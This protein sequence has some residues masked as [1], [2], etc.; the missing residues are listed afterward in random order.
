MLNA[1]RDP[2]FVLHGGLERFSSDSPYKSHCPACPDGILIVS[3]DPDTFNL[4][5]ADRCVVCAQA[6]VYA[7][8]DS[9]RIRGAEG[10]LPLHGEL[11]L[12]RIVAFVLLR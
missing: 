5:R 9:Y 1:R 12:M 8:D 6:V 10:F 3:R 4:S 2:I 7:D 11:E